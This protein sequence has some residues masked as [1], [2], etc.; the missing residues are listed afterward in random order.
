[1]TTIMDV[2]VPQK[3]KKKPS[4]NLADW[5]LSFA[6][7]AAKMG[8]SDLADF[9]EKVPDEYPPVPMFRLTRFLDYY[10]D[11]LSGVPSCPWC[12]MFKD[13]DLASLI[14]VPLTHIP[15][16]VLRTSVEWLNQQVPKSVRTKDYVPK[17]ELLFIMGKTKLAMFVTL[18]MILRSKPHVLI[19]V[20]PSL[21]RFAP[22]YQVQ[23]QIPLTLW[24]ITQATKDDLSL[25]LLS[26]AHNLLPLV[27]SHPQSTDAILDFV[28][29]YVLLFCNLQNKKQKTLL[30]A[31]LSI[32]VTSVV[33]NFVCTQPTTSRFKAIY[34]LLKQLALVR[35]TSNSRAIIEEKIFTVSLRLSG[36][37]N[38]ALAEEARSIALWSLTVD[39]DCW[40]MWRNLCD[41]NVK[42]SLDIFKT[43]V[44]KFKDGELE[45]M[46]EKIF[47]FS[48]YLA[49]RGNLPQQATAIWSLNII[50]DCWKQRGNISVDNL[51]ACVRL[52]ENL[53]ERC[54]EHSFNGSP[55]ASD[56]FA[57]SPGSKARKQITRK[58]FTLCLKLAGEGEEAA[59]SIA[60]WCLSENV[61]CWKN[62]DNIYEENREASVALLKTLL[63]EWKDHSLDLVLSPSDALVIG[64]TMKSF[65]L[66][67]KNAIT[68]GRAKA[69]LYKEADK[70]CKVLSW[71]LSRVRSTL[72]ATTITAMV[73]VAVVILLAASRHNLFGHLVFWFGIGSCFSV[74]GC[75]VLQKLKLYINHL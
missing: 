33:F 45:A 28:E 6:T 30:N 11:A 31:C 10:D 57:G 69:S 52:L 25:G 61:D 42:V 12:K 26:W 72:K 29:K 53:I 14:D 49:E 8:P 34:P 66:Q 54:T 41:R 24:F 16:P 65:M 50:V 58:I 73:L 39:K 9:L 35:T 74:Y 47:N 75:S 3:K 21:R 63:E 38:T 27:D 37:E 13:S 1:M 51:K 44:G 15:E 46:N 48:F 4:G 23:G 7:V 18:A 40:E 43:L 20:L 64:Q 56:S 67:N 36:E 60:S 70:S 2:V 17:G 55:S 22:F 59:T 71:R 19:E 32:L 68:E 62:W 5:E